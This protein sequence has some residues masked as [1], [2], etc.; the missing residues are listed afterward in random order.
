MGHEVL[1][2]CKLVSS[3]PIRITETTIYE[4]VFYSELLFCL[5]LMSMD[6]WIHLSFSL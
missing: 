1:T 2:D 3:I 4:F 5:S 6:P